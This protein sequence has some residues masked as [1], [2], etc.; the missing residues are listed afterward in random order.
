MATV[1]VIVPTV[2]SNLLCPPIQANGACGEA[3]EKLG[4]GGLR[5]RVLAAGVP[6]FEWCAVVARGLVRA[7]VTDVVEAA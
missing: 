2:A 4:P 6:R 7:A 3:G 5:C 1:L